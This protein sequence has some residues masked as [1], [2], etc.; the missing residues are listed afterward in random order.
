MKPFSM[1]DTYGR[2]L[3]D[4]QAE[5][6]NQLQIDAAEEQKRF[7]NTQWLTGAAK[8]ALDNDMDP[9]IIASI[10]QEGQRRGVLGEFD[11]AATTREEMIDIYKQGMT[12]LQGYQEPG[13]SKGPKIQNAEWMMNASPEAKQAYMTANYAGRTQVIGGVPHWVFPG[14]E[15]LPLGTIEGEMSG[16]QNIAA[17][18]AGGTASVVPAAT[19]SQVALKS[20]RVAA[21]ARRLQNM[22]ERNNDMRSKFFKGGK[23]QEEIASIS[24][25]GQAFEAARAQLSAELL[26]LTR[27]PGIG[28]QSDFEARLQEMTLPSLSFHPDVNDQQIAELEIFLQDLDQAFENLQ[29]GT[30]QPLPSQQNTGWEA[31]ATNPE[32]GEKMGYR[33]GQ[34]QPIK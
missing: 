5:E 24:K 22:V 1:A 9:E 11:P 14:G 4:R 18:R 6:A 23:F 10:G 16:A 30:F 2:G 19:R 13:E 28:A 29:S 20:P 17:A 3:Q 34:W 21:G 7:Q 27:V 33:N 8:F 15:K 25:E 31:T 12:A 26:A 32:T